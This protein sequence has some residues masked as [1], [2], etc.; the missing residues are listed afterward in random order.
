MQ[1][2]VGLLVL[3][4][5][6]AVIVIT[7][8]GWRYLPEILADWVGTIVGIMSTPFLLEI[9][10]IFIGLS[11]VVALNH[12]RHKRAGEDYVELEVKETEE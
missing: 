5:L 1:V 6:T 11:I 7:L 9:S 10:F 12:W 2:V 3:L 4:V 8:A